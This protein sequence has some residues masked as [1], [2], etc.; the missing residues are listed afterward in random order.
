MLQT[1]EVPDGFITGNI[2]EFGI[3]KSVEQG[4]KNLLN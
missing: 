4:E 3:S 1:S 2:H